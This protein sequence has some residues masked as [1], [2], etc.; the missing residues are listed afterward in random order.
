MIGSYCQWN[1]GTCPTMAQDKNCNWS[2]ILKSATSYNFHYKFAEIIQKSIYK[3]ENDPFR[4][5]NGELLAKYATNNI[6]G[7]YEDCYYSTSGN[8]ITLVCSWR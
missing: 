4:T 1:E 5:F 8:L 3:M 2:T 7:K 6:T